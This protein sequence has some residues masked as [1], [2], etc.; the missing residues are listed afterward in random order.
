MMWC[1]FVLVFSDL[2]YF[3]LSF[4]SLSPHSFDLRVGSLSC[5][6]KRCKAFKLHQILICAQEFVVLAVLYFI[7]YNLCIFF[8][9]PFVTH[10][11][12]NF[13]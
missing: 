12:L 3:S 8:R 13:S 4:V 10:P 1:P 5:L 6:V 7:M 9:Y 11:Q 2:Y